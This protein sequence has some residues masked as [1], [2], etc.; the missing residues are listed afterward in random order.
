MEGVSN[1]LESSTI[2]GLS[3]F[4]TTRKYARLFWI[5]VVITGFVG[6]SLL[7]KESFD[8]WSE[9]PVKTTI[10]TLP[11]SEIKLPNVTICPPKN[12]FTDLNYDLMMTENMTL[13]EEMRD[14]MFEYALEVINADTKNIAAGLHDEDRFYNWY[15]G[16]TE[17]SLQY[18]NEYLGGLNHDIFTAAISGVVSTQF[19][20]QQFISK[21]V[22]K[23]IHQRVFVFPPKSVRNNANVTLHFSVEK[24]SMTTTGLVGGGGDRVYIE[25]IG[26]LDA[27]QTIAYTNFTPPGNYSSSITYFRDVSSEEVEQQSLEVMPGFRLRWWYTGVEV[28]PERQYKDEEM[29]KLFVR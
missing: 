11:I 18:I 1:Y 9:S 21:R 16:Y 5:T 10:E 29:T 14:E 28:T 15:Y 22:E 3:Y 12:T 19:Y 7:I 23:K 6:A 8:S 4:S 20:G 27:D 2:H 13:T 17:I 24:V 25:G 26:N